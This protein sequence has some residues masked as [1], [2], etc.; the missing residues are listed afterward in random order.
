M[1]VACFALFFLSLIGH[2]WSGWAKFNNDQQEKGQASVSLVHFL[3]SG[4][5]METLF[6]NWESEF[7]QMGIYVVLTAMLF[8]LGSP[9]SKKP[10]DSPPTEPKIRK[11]SPWPVKK[12]GFVAKLYAHSLSVS[13]LLLF[14]LSFTL[15]VIGGARAH[16]EKAVEEH[17]PTMTITE[18]AGSSELWYQSFQNW[19][20]EFLSIGLIVV[21]SIY[22]RE[23]GSSQS[24]A[25]EAPHSETGS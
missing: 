12:G 8:Q 20:S 5:F 9:E 24:K 14:V 16:N 19:Q 11:D 21:L 6:E 1:S 22:F 3:G 23:R 25:V 4:D 17:R 2:V 7:L 13:L 18:F 10:D 15:H